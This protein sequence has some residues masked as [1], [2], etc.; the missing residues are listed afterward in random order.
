MDSQIKAALILG[1]AII[2]AVALWI[3]FGPYHS[4]VRAGYKEIACAAATGG[5]LPRP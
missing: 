4:C 2:I 5:G 3:Y 1:G